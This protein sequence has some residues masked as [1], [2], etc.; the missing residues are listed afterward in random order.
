MGGNCPSW[1]GGLS[2]GIVQGGIVR[3]PTMT[4]VEN[5]NEKVQKTRH[6]LRNMNNM[7]PTCKQ[8][9]RLECAKIECCHIAVLSLN[10]SDSVSN[11]HQHKG[12]ECLNMISEA[13]IH[14]KS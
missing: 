10:A 5:H 9:G 14:R 2:G 13:S 7:C 12:N 6:T 11:E 1:E 4:T 3:S 8:H